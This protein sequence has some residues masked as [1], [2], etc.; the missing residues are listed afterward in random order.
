MI[1]KVLRSFR[2]YRKLHGGYWFLYR[3]RIDAVLWYEWV[4]YTI[5]T[6]SPL[7]LLD[8]PNPYLTDKC[9]WYDA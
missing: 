6:S 8:Y 5:D 3:F 2:W 7:N 9:E 4:S 1:S